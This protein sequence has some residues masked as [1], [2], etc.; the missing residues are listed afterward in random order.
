MKTSEV[1]LDADRY[2]LTYVLYLP[3]YSISKLFQS[4][5][6]A[7]CTNFYQEKVLSDAG[8]KL[9]LSNTSSFLPDNLSGLKKIIFQFADIRIGISIRK[10]TT[11]APVF[12][13]D[14]CKI[15]RNTFFSRNPPMDA[16][17]IGED[18]IANIGISLNEKKYKKPNE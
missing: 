8:L 17:A 7:W 13:C 15:L 14:F 18:F 5:T 2:V 11:Q 10:E 12:S 1:L 16:S 3:R 6:S 9:I 4:H